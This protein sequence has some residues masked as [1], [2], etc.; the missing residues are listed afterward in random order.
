MNTSDRTL[1][2]KNRDV[3][4]KNVLELNKNRTIGETSL[5]KKWNEK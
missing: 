5:T 1:V 2:L 3:F 4:I